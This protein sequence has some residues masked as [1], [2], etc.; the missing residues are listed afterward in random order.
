[1]PPTEQRTLRPRDRLHTCQHRP[2]NWLRLCPVH[3]SVWETGP[4]AW[5]RGGK[6]SELAWAYLLPRTEVLP[7]LLSGSFG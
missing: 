7:Q 1:M 2:W 6:A 4:G 3:G 5:G